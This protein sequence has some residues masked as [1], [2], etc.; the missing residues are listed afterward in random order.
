M[1]GK[2]GHPKVL[3]YVSEWELDEIRHELTAGEDPAFVAFRH[4]VPKRYITRALAYKESK[5]EVKFK[6]WDQDSVQFVRE[7]YPIHGKDWEG[8]KQLGRTWKAIQTKACSIGMGN[9]DMMWSQQEIDFLRENYA[10]HD[11]NWDGWG[12]L[13]RS[14]YAISNKA[15][16]MKIATRKRGRRKK[17]V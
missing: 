9:S 11:K 1:G 6:R 2:T 4:G 16:M 7:N 14:W 12:Q 10:D 13:N 5:P 15:H 8:W 17:V 3:D